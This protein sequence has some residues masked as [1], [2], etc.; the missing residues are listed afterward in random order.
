M[1]MPNEKE[2]FTTITLTPGI[3]KKHGRTEAG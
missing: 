3:G 1:V 2:Q